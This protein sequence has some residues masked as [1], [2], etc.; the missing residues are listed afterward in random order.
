MESGQ[1]DTVRDRSHRAA[2]PSDGV[3]HRLDRAHE[4][5][6]FRTGQP[7]CNSG[8]GPQTILIPSI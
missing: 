6:G 7:F 1:G 8:P 5:T 3:Y 2:G 4:T